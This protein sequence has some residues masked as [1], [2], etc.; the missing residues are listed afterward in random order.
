MYTSLQLVTT[1]TTTL[2]LDPVSISMASLATLI[3]GK[4]AGLLTDAEFGVN[5]DIDAYA[6]LSWPLVGVGLCDSGA[7]GTL[8][9]CT[10]KPQLAAWA[11]FLNSPWPK[12]RAYFLNDRFLN[13]GFAL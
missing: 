3:Q 2:G 7:S 8:I 1:E 6:G 4:L 9:S 11:N 5:G 13:T 10:R 12:A